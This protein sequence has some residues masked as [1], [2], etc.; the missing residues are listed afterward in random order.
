MPIEEFEMTAAHQLQQLRCEKFAP[1]AAERV[2]STENCQ[3]SLL[4]AAE[5]TRIVAE[6][7]DACALAMLR[8]NY[9]GIDQ[10]IR[11]QADK[12]AEQGFASSDIEELLRI[13]REAAIEVERWDKDIF[14]DVEEVLRE[15]LQAA[16]KQVG[17]PPVNYVVAA[18][19]DCDSGAVEVVTE[20]RTGERRIYFRNRLQFPVRICG[21]GGKW[22]L[23][24]IT[25]T[26]N[27][28]RGG[29]YIVT[30]VKYLA[31][32]ALKVTYPYW[33]DP[34]AIN[35]EYK[36]LVSRLDRL[37]DGTSGVAIAFLE[38]PSGKLK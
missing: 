38:N 28:S 4:P 7:Y 17:P 31:D 36:A 35:L 6:W 29:L 26:H 21:V 1:I 15:A 34:G 10:W 18:P 2:R 11:R 25:S 8:G 37:A 5:L 9:A 20:E 16:F 3:Y 14:S 32:Q 23:D 19:G 33:T 12:G 27:I 24:E 13:C 22:Q 30:K